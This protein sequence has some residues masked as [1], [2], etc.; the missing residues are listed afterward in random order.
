MDDEGE[1]YSVAQLNAGEFQVGNLSVDPL[2]VAPGS[3]DF[4]LSPGS[5]M[6]D[7]GLD[8]GLPFCGNAPDL[9]AIEV[10]P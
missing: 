5:P 3:E 9:G 8:I 4:R 2:F 6:I 10:C 7:A 1:T